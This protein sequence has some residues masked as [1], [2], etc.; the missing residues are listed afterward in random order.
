VKPWLARTLLWGAI[1]LVLLAGL[2]LVLDS[3]WTGELEKQRGSRIAEAQRLLPPLAPEDD[4][5]P[6]CRAA[7]QQLDKWLA[8]PDV[9]RETEKADNLLGAD[10]NAPERWSEQQAA[11]YSF[12]DA[13]EPRAIL[14]RVR[15]L[16]LRP[17]CR[18]YEVCE[19]GGG[20]HSVHPGFMQYGQ[21][22]ER[23]CC[24]ALLRGERAEAADH[25]ESAFAYS[26]HLREVPLVCA[27]EESDDALLG[28]A[29][30]L[31]IHEE[32]G[33]L[34]AQ[35]A[36][37]LLPWL[38]RIQPLEDWLRAVDGERMLFGQYAWA[39]LREGR[40]P[41]GVSHPTDPLGLLY[42]KLLRPWR[43]LQQLKYEKL[44]D[45]KRSSIESSPWEKHPRPEVPALYPITATLTTHAELDGARRLSVRHARDLAEI[46]LR[47]AIVHAESG[48]YPD[49][50]DE[51]GELPREPRTNA[52]YVYARA[53]G[54]YALGLPER[55]AK[56]PEPAPRKPV[57][58][59]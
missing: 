35:L 13:A 46:T 47:L 28:A 21:M 33:L 11:L 20:M 52:P 58:R 4:A 26:A 23:E 45:E 29:K 3:K 2:W 50:L 36:G 37:R 16:L 6:A 18:I 24:R 15:E 30:L 49:A 32:R 43:L 48:L 25:V 34:D 5:G 1:A 17:H 22:L 53:G 42:S 40:A 55:A 39:G 19:S 54:G 41:D 8:R 51:L 14:S 12:C 56:S 44:L 10:R 38:G 7:L 9:S 57:R 59:R 27:C 31:R